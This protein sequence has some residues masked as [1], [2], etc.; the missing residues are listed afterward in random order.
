MKYLLP[1]AILFI[2]AL[3]YGLGISQYHPPILPDELVPQNAPGYYDYRGVTHSHTSLNKGTLSPEEVI[4]EAQVARLDFLILTDLNYFLPYPI[5]PDYYQN[6]LVMV[7]KSYSY[8]DSHILHYSLE[9]LPQFNGLGE[10]QVY[11]SDRLSKTPKEETDDFVVLAHPF[12]GGRNWSGPYPKSLQG[13]E[14]INL[15]SVWRIAWEK[16]KPSFFWSI[17][18]SSLNLYFYFLSLF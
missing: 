4:E 6:L 8:L 9:Q 7:G 15:K 13:I 1:P 5:K 10:A 3:A 18:I 11:F 17:F 12:K 2:L 16:T 14:T